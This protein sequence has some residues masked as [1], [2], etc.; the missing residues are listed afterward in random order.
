MSPSTLPDRRDPIV[1][2]YD[3][4]QQQERDLPLRS[5]LGAGMCQECGRPKDQCRCGFEV[6]YDSSG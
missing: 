1:E 5:C 2:W 4:L 3:Y 6:T